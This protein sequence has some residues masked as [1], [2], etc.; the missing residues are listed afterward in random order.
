MSLC[1]STTFLGYIITAGRI[2]MD[3][4]KMRAVE[5][6]PQ[7]TNRKSLQRFLGFTNFYRRFIHSYSSIAAPIMCLTS[8]KVR[9]TWGP[10]AEEAFRSL[11]GRFTS[12]PILVHPDPERQFIMEV[13]ASNTGLGA[14]LSQR[15]AGDAKV[16]L[17]AFYSHK[18]SPAERN[19]DIGNKELLA[20]KLTIEEWRQ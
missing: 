3:P 2:A 10:E 11:K 13:D 8:T 6:W 16:H 18:L 19:Y 12:A 4:K 15:S 14:V 20:V 7:P 9:F 5:Q 1:S 17:C